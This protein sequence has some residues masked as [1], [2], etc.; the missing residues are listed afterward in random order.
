MAR[1]RIDNR[2]ERAKRPPRKA[3]YW[4]VIEPG[5]AI[6]YHRPKVG[7]GAWW[8]RVLIG[9]DQYKMIALGVA[10][11]QGAGMGWKQAQAKVREWAAK[12]TGAGPLTVEA[13]IVAYTDDLRAR[14]SARAADEAFGRMRK[15]LFPV[16]GA[17]PLADLS[18]AD[19]TAWRNGLVDLK[20]DEDEIRKCRDTANRLLAIAK[21]A[22]NFAF[23]NGQVG[24]DRAWRRVKGFRGVGEARK[25]FLSEAELQR[26]IDA[27]GPGLRELVAIGVLTGA[28]LGELT[29]A[30]VRDFDAEAAIL[31]RQR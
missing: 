15:H 4:Q 12:Q 19:L 31:H 9:A 20:A 2:T 30:R 13:A 26:L 25:I 17:R 7:A 11:D 3:P 24:D 8:A 16:L 29:G 22:F 1:C 18:P 14:K 28:R 27:C 6:G 5:L 23:N 10:D 21:A